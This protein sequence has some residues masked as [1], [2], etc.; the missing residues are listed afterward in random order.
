MGEFTRCWSTCWFARA[1]D[2]GRGGRDDRRELNDRIAALGRSYV[3][4]ALLPFRCECNRPGCMET[5]TLRA[6]EHDAIRS[7][8]EA[9]TVAP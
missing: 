2:V 1:G 7:R 4:P 6:K 8:G 3:V 9:V 5:V